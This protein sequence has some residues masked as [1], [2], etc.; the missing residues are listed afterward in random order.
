MN[1]SNKRL[2]MLVTVTHN[3]SSANHSPSKKHAVS[4]S[5]IWY[6]IHKGYV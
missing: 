2:D 3:V 4:Y 1:V 6:I 5:E